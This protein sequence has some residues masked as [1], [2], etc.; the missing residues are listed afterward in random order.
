MKPFANVCFIVSACFVSLFKR[1]VCMQCALEQYLWAVRCHEPVILYQ[2]L[3]TSR[4]L[5]L[6]LQLSSA[7]GFYSSAVQAYWGLWW[8]GNAANLLS[9]FTKAVFEASPHGS[10]SPGHGVSISHSQ[11]V[12]ITGCC[13]QHLLSSPLSGVTNPVS[14]PS[15]LSL[16]LEVEILQGDSRIVGGVCFLWV[17]G[18]V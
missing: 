10:V 6:T 5:L 11:L 1:D 15:V 3:A 18:Q 8:K 4:R 13:R 17:R 14:G 7:M 9:P 12:G 2:C 16:V